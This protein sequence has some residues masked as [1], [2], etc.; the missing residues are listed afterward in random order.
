MMRPATGGGCRPGDGI[1][2]LRSEL[3]TAAKAIRQGDEVRLGLQDVLAQ[4]ICLLAEFRL[5][6]YRRK[7]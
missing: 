4:V 1:N 5:R 6:S 2:A 7:A 3:H